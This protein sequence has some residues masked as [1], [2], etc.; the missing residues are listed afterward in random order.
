MTE[1]ILDSRYYP[2][3]HLAASVGWINDPNGFCYYN[4]EYH[5]FYQYH[6]YSPQWGPMHWGHAT[7]TDLITWKNQPVALAPDKDYDRGGCFSGS[8]IE[9]DG[10]LYLMY[11][12]HIPDGPQTQCLA[13]S[14]DG[15]TFEK[16]EGNPVLRA[17]ESE[18]ISPIDFRDPK[19]WK[20][21]KKYFCTVGSKTPDELGQVLL[22]ESDNLIDWNF[23]AISARAKDP[24]EKMWE[25]PNFAE[26]DNGALLIMSV[27]GGEKFR[28]GYI[29]G[30][31]SYKTGNFNGGDFQLIDYGTDFYA[32]Q[33]TTS[34]DGRIIMMGWLSMWNV[35]MPE[36]EDGW[37]GLMTVPREITF[38]NGKVKTPPA[39][40][41]EKL[42]GE[43]STHKNFSLTKKSELDN[44]SG[45]VGEIVLDID[46]KNNPTFNIEFRA[47]DDEKTVLSYSENSLKLDCSESGAG[48]KNICECELEKSDT[49]N[50]RIFLDK[51]SVEVFANDGEK[52]ISARIYPKETS[53][54]VYFVPVESTLNI[55]SAIF[56]KIV[57]DIF[58]ERTLVLIKPDVFAKNHTGDILKRYEDAGFKICAAK[59]MQMDNKIASI[60]YEEHR[61]KIFYKDLVEFMTSGPLMAVVLSGR[62]VIERVRAIN[63][64]TNPANAAE[65]TIRKLYAEDSSKNAVHASD[66]AESAE[67][68]I[69][70]FFSEL[71]IF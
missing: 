34:P 16:F 35:A 20:H 5:M 10:K 32:P 60:H 27:I 46:L 69:K 51:S 23:K 40:E 24:D 64:A 41:L 29:T 52:V 62:K 31:F 21:G 58:T 15:I 8:A 59:V 18:E 28:T 19:V 55:N 13:V 42:R 12:G 45:D 6:P 37:A 47:G 4:G 48:P 65:G 3:Y 25:C 67:R 22:F 56:Y 39:K 68:E 71:E 38:N 44:F 17:P 30:K 43:H 36:Q 54:R 49:L 9:K 70:I 11:T 14:E 57:E 33:I 50:L 26:F 61:E 7:S 53:Q 1:K 2:K 63:G 66:S